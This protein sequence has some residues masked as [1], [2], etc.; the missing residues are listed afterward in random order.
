MRAVLVEQQARPSTPLH[1]DLELPIRAIG[2]PT[3]DNVF[4]GAM[5]RHAYD[6]PTLSLTYAS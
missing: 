4:N 2:S 5:T 1:L 6:P 3:L